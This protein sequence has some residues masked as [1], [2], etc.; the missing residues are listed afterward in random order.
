M[1][2]S[3]TSAR[4]MSRPRM[5]ARLW[6]IAR[7]IIGKHSRRDRG[8]I[9]RYAKTEPSARPAKAGDRSIVERFY[10]ERAIR[11]VAEAFERDKAAGRIS[12]LEA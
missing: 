1:W 12:L 10:Q 3:C 6:S 7:R 2:E 8:R 11:R 9:L 5:S 4:G